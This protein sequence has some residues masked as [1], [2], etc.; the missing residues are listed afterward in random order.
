MAYFK[1]E[2]IILKKRNFAEADRLLNIYTKDYGKISAIAKGARRPR[3]RKGGHLE[4]GNWCKIFVAQGKNI[5]ILT[6]V[7]L[8]QPFGLINFTEQKANKIY[9]LLEIVDLLS[10]THQKNT[11]VFMLLLDFLKRIE[12]HEDFD[13]LSCAFKVRLLSNLGF[14]SS[15]TLKNSTAKNVLM[16]F[17]QDNLDSIK[18]NLKLSAKS[19]LNLL[20][21][22]D[23][24]IEDLAQS[25]LSTARFLWSEQ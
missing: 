9:H 1:T 23:S 13:S 6:E 4:L 11:T 2:G 14:F 19:Y 12:D 20:V 18:K 17:E 25:K 16:S 10:V 22:L 21:F 15:Q 3:S 7:E 5:D 8:K 24:I